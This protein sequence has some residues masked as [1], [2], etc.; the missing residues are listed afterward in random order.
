MSN[1]HLSVGPSDIGL[2]EHRVV[3]SRSA[4]IAEMKAAQC[5]K[6]RE[7]R[8]ALNSDGIVFLTE[9]AQAFGLSRSTTWAV[10]SGNHK[11]AGLS[12]SIIKRILAS[13]Q[14]PS[15]AR[16]VILEY[17]DQKLSGAY[18]HSAASLRCFRTKLGFPKRHNALSRLLTPKRSLAGASCCSSEAT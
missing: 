12:A 13:P 2:R 10:L 5:A 17:V 4:T 1:Q 14:C 7:L 6:I 9:Q 18:G 8:H 3:E 16:K 15:N 11:S